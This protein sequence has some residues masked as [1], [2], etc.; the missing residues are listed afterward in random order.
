MLKKTL[1]VT[2]LIATLTLGVPVISA[3]DTI[4]QDQTQEFEVT[5]ETGSYGQITKCKAEGRQEQGQKIVYRDRDGKPAT[6][7]YRDGRKI[8]IPVDTAVDSRV[9]LAGLT[10]VLGAALMAVLASGK[11]AK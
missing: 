1:A 2:A 8:H 3:E 10:F 7:I 6:A 5:C 9:V 11:L 4:E